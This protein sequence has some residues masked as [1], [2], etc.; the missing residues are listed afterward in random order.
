[1]G[2]W[3]REC[4]DSLCMNVYNPVLSCASYEFITTVK[5][6][7]AKVFHPSLSIPTPIFRCWSCLPSYSH[8]S[9]S[10]LS[11]RQHTNAPPRGHSLT[12]KTEKKYE[13]HK[14]QVTLLDTATLECVLISDHQETKYW[15]EAK[16]I[17]AQ[18]I[19]TV[20]I[21]VGSKQT[22]KKKMDVEN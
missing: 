7:R 21:E 4:S 1:M 2:K 15:Q 18:K 8:L 10:S 3:R 14:S 5:W 13:N 9:H 20:L 16:K 12:H 17:L 19:F 22:S 6:W 11:L